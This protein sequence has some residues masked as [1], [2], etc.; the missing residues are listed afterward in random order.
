MLRNIIKIKWWDWPIDK[1][2]SSKDFFLKDLEKVIR[3]GNI[4]KFTEML[5][6]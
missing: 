6:G 1:I 2:K 5:F 4:K 3:Y